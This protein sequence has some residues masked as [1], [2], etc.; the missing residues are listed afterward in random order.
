MRFSGDCGCCPSVLVYKSRF[1]PRVLGVWLLL[2]CLPYLA[3]SVAA[4]MWPQYAARVWNILMPLT[5]GELA[6]MLWLI[7]MGAR[8]R[9]AIP[10]SA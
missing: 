7:V 5:L 9:D 8:E 3:H 1:L 6:I 4:V 2:N 10:A